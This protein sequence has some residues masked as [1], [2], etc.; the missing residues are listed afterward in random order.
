MC[1]FPFAGFWREVEADE[2]YKREGHQD[3]QFHIGDFN[4]KEDKCEDVY[5]TLDVEKYIAG[6]HGL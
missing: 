3:E 2:G 1:S 6:G 4:G 5:D